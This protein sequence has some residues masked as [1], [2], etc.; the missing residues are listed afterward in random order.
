MSSSPSKQA[1][2]TG[3]DSAAA[4]TTNE[5]ISQINSPVTGRPLATGSSPMW[6]LR[7]NQLKQFRASFGHTNV[8]NKFKDNPQLATWV[9]EQRRHYRK[10]KVDG[11]KTSLTD[12]RIAILEG[13]GFQWS[14]H[15]SQ[16]DV[17][18]RLIVML[19]LVRCIAYLHTMVLII[20]C[21]FVE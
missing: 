5:Q 11:K 4:Y 19:M 9:T 14:V 13:I 10:T 2:T 7:F 21:T 15:E 6:D 1:K 17:S 16:W 18:I 8:P 3:D 12:E 20:L